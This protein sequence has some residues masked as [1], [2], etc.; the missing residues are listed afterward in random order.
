MTPPAGPEWQLHTDVDSWLPK[1]LAGL[2]AL[3]H[4]LVMNC[5]C[6]A[7]AVNARLGCWIH[8][9]GEP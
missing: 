3:P 4:V 7:N 9:G 5:S 6:A 8:K 1:N 2:T